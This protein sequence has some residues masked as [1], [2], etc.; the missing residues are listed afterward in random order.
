MLLDRRDFT[1][2]MFLV[3]DPWSRI[4]RVTSLDAVGL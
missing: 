3:G 2:G 1:Y 4:T